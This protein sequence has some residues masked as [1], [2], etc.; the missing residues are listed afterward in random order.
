VVLRADGL[1]AALV[2]DLLVGDD[3]RPRHLAEAVGTPTVG[4]SSGPPW[5]WAR[6]SAEPHVPVRPDHDAV[7]RLRPL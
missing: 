6:C 4:G 7:P 3:S 2:A 5:S 1:G